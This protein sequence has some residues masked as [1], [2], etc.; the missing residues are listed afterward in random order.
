MDLIEIDAASNRGIDDIRSLRDKIRL[1]PSAAKFKVYIIDEVHMLTTEAFNALLK[2]LEEPPAHALFILCTTEKRKVPETIRSRCL[3]FEFRRAAVGDIVKKLEHICEQEKISFP[4]EKLLK[5]A[6]MAEGGYRDAETILEQAVSGEGDMESLPMNISPVAELASDIIDNRTKEALLVVNRLYQQGANLSAFTQ[7]LIEYWHNLLLILAG[8]GEIVESGVEEKEVMS[9]YCTRLSRDR[10]VDITTEFEAAYSQLKSTVIPT[11]PLELAVVKLTSEEEI[12]PSQNE[13]D[14]SDNK[15]EA[16]EKVKNDE[17]GFLAASC[18]VSV[19]PAKAGI[20]SGSPIRSGMTR[21][22]AGNKSQERFTVDMPKASSDVTAVKALDWELVTSKWEELLKA[23]RPYNHS[24]EAL[25]RSAKPK[26]AG[27]GK[28]QIEVLY[29]FHKDRLE[30]K[31]NHDILEKVMA[32]VYGQ[33]VK[34]A[35]LLAEKK[36]DSK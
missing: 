23:I 8:V 2:T 29:K 6:K 31:K 33:P 11:L 20:Q 26:V 24:L 28:L 18:G 19:I 9:K 10:L 13:K 36:I 15:D 14:E 32:E 35:C 5:I 30:E 17:M 27:D 3:Q 1:V 34:V 4:K 7:E 22:A 16:A 25:M 12:I 21:Q